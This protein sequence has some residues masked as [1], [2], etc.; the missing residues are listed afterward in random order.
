MARIKEIDGLRGFALFGILMT[1]MFEGYLA[2]LTPPQYADFNILYPIDGATRFVIRNFFIGKFYAIFSL[3]FGLSFYLILG[4]KEQSSAWR[5]AWRMILL[6]LIGFL[7][8]VHYRG[9]FLTVY[10][11][12]GLALIPFRRVP[13]KVV[14][15]LG[16]FL[17]LNGPMLIS[18]GVALSSP[19]TASRT[20]EPVA[21]APPAVGTP[22]TDP[23]SMANAYFSLIL[24]GE[25]RALLQSNATIGV[26]NKIN[27]L[28][29]SGRMFVIP[30]LFLLGLW[31]GR[32]RLHERL[33]DLPVARIVAWTALMGL[34]LVFVGH[35]ARL[36]GNPGLTQYLGFIALHS[37]NLLVPLMYIGLL[38]LLFRSPTPR[39]LL[40]RL[41]PVGRMGLSVYVLQST[42]GILIFYGYGLG[43]LLT[44]SGTLALAAGVLIFLGIAGFCHW[45]FIRFRFGPLEW[46]WRSATMMRLQPF[47][48][49]A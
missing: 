15:L 7:H 24:N 43:L 46:I 38:L 17:A 31:V 45:W 13:D 10:A 2:S 18:K 19:A 29:F 3:L 42:I 40:S 26:W 49:D 4:R 12:F 16:L 36:P 35:Y 11:V 23:I 21:S 39:A 48:R 44:L 30:G 8:H 41:A 28:Q 32:K 6:F 37:S 47:V 1:H 14:L 22:K 9:D 5:F 33:A 25:Y 20:T 34:P 27:Y